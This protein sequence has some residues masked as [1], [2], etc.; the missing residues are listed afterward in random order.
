MH[1][2]LKFA[3][4]ALVSLWFAGLCFLPW[5]FMAHRRGEAAAY[6]RHFNRSANWAYFRLATPAAALAILL[7]MALMPYAQPGAWL[8]AKLVLVALAVLL[9]VYFGLVLYEMGKGNDRHGVWFFRVAGGV[10]MLLA[11]AL[12]GITAAKPRTFLGLP[13]PPAAAAIPA[14]EGA[15]AAHH[16]AGGT[17]S[18]PSSASGSYS[19]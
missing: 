3:H 17:S 19:P 11:L 16:S 2:W 12:A 18:S 13:A 4:I 14:G 8:V 6:P 15:D 5:L 7:G 9:H 1:F 10:P